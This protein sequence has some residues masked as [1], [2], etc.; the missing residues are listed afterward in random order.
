MTAPAFHDAQHDIT[1]QDC[2]G[3]VAIRQDGRCYIARRWKLSDE[4][5][6][7]VRTALQFGLTK[8]WQCGNPKGRESSRIS[9]S[10][11]HAANSWVFALGLEARPPQLRR[12]TFPRRLL[13]AFESAAW[14]WSQQSWGSRDILVPPSCFPSALLLAVAASA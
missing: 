5:E 3:G 7:V 1:I 12:I 14:E 11:S 8:L 13:P 2:E 4:L 9:F 10:T 6:C